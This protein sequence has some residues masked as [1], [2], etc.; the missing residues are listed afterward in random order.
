MRELHSKRITYV[1]GIFKQYCT[2]LKY[3]RDAYIRNCSP[4]FERSLTQLKKSRSK[5]KQLKPNRTNKR[6][7]PK[8]L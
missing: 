4:S 7:N 1:V 3:I 8:K 5:C 6:N 2:L